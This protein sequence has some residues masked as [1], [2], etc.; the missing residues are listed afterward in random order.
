[1]VSFSTTG[2]LLRVA[3]FRLGTIHTTLRYACRSFHMVY[4]ADHIALGRGIWQR[5]DRGA[6][7]Q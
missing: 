1:M 7:L 3:P 6:H 4:N 5:L 2:L